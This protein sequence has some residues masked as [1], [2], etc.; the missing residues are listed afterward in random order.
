MPPLAPAAIFGVALLLASCSGSGA[1]A[2]MAAAVDAGGSDQVALIEK[3]LFGTGDEAT[4]TDFDAE[5]QRIATREESV[6]ACMAS[7]GFEYYVVTPDIDS[8][9]RS[10]VDYF[11]REYAETYGFGYTTTMD[12]PSS[13]MA[14]DYSDANTDYTQ[15]LS[16]GELDEYYLALYG[17]QSVWD[18]INSDEERIALQAEEPELFEPSGC[19]ADATSDQDR[20][21]QAFW[22][23]HNDEISELYD[24]AE[25]SASVQEAVTVWSRCMNDKGHQF[26][27]PDD[28]DSVMDPYM[29]E[30]YSTASHPA[31]NVS[32]EQQQE[33][34][35]EELN[36]LW[37]QPTSYDQDLLAEAQDYEIEIAVASWDCGME[38]LYDV[39]SAEV[40]DLQRT[41]I[42]S[43]LTELTSLVA[44]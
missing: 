13:T 1:D 21:S 41:F 22:T 36:E 28:F 15:T 26:S 25:N 18:N 9:Q 12:H 33:M 35:D 32:D 10:D 39:Y 42:E 40:K 14:E 4:D 31:D 2:E 8:Y 20:A 30:I 44:S 11:S 23:E 7:A 24:R 37:S 38:D 27:D 43:N 16:Q 6:A 34:T 5:I 17:D 3:A 19:Q 29:E